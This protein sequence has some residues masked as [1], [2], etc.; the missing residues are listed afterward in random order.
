M[1]AHHAEWLSLACDEWRDAPELQARWVRWVLDEVLELRDAVAEATD[2][3]PSHRVAEHGVTLRPSFVVH[4]HS[5]EGGPPVL[6]V[7][8]HPEGTPA[9]PPASGG[10]VGGEP[11][12]PRRRAGQGDSDAARARH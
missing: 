4:D 8:T 9:G 7:R 12:R 2:A 5:R 11:G 6:L 3:D 10:G 1:E